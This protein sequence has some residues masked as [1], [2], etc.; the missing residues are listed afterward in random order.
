MKIQLN[1][2]RRIIRATIAECY[3]W[4]VESEK[5][6]YNISHKSS[7]MKTPKGPNS[8]S[9]LGESFSRIS[10]REMD[11]WR[12]GNWGFLQEDAKE[13]LCEGC[14]CQLNECGCGE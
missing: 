2:L 14:G 4:P 11:E 7:K 10:Q 1:E 5:P 6:L 8:R 12:R 3:G 9:R 13:D